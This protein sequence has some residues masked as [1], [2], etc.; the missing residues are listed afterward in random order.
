M[1]RLFATA[2]VLLASLIL[3]G[4]ALGWLLLPALG[5]AEIKQ[6]V[7]RETGRELTFA[8]QP[9]LTL[10][11]E[12]AI[13]LSDI[14]LSNPPDMAEGRFAAAD[15][16]RLK[17]SATSLWRRLPVVTEIVVEGARINLLVDSE[18]RSNFAFEGDAGGQ[19]EETALVPPIV[20]VDGSLKYLNERTAAAFAVSDVDATLARSGFAGPIELD[21]AFNWNEQ[22]LKLALFARSSSRLTAQG[23][24][25][26]FTLAGPHLSAAFSGRAAL[27]DGLELAG[28]VQFKA[29]PLAGLLS[30]AGHGTALGLP[31]LSANGALDLSL[32][33]IRIGKAQLA[34]GGIDATGD[35]AL[36]FTG[37]KPHIK[38]ALD[39]DRIDA[40]LIEADLELE[41]LKMVDAEL[42]LAVSEIA[43]GTLVAGASRL[44]VGL[45][46]GRL[47]IAL[48]KAEL[49]GGSAT[50]RVTFDGSTP[51]AALEARIEARGV[52]G[53]RLSAGLTGQ[54]RIRGQTEIDLDLATRGTSREELVAR[55]KGRAHLS[56]DAGALVDLDVAAMLGRVT[57][58]VAEGWTAAGKGQT[59]FSRL[60]ARFAVEDGIAETEDLR[61]EGPAVAV[62]GT[63]SIDLLRRRLD[64][65]L[66]PRTGRADDEAT[67]K[68]LPVAVVIAGP[69]SAPKFHPDVEGILEDP[70]KAVEALRRRIEANAAKLD[71]G[72]AESD[73][74]QGEAAVTR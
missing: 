40:G 46:D 28:T 13:E 2:G 26:D 61:L 19:P 58:G 24:P 1:T 48:E 16:V 6:A 47:D 8:G 12:L 44:D 22:R 3:G 53:G 60:E 38:A 10:W 30:W 18:G 7:G 20:I 66:Q 32:G 15:K 9:R 17:V 43:Y 70:A 74:D 34:F 65:K 4:L 27:R 54:E 71:L 67:A 36:G 31:D 51:V 25:A 57:T 39:V 56:F 45:A 69:W 59:P 42:S 62:V 33:A 23:S 55:L 49:Y 11:P 14:E 73:K 63:G 52:D 29:E 68:T 5:E 72:P 21:G 37:P 35:V 64:L 50:G 41:F